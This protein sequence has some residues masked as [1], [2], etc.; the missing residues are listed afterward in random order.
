LFVLNSQQGLPVVCQA[1][2][3]R[4]LAHPLPLERFVSQYLSCTL[5]NDVTLPLGYRAEDVQYQLA[6]GC[7][8]V[9][10]V[11]DGT[12]INA[13]LFEYVLCEITEVTN[14]PGEAIEL[15]DDNYVEV[16]P[17]AAFYDLLDAFSIEVLG[18]YPFVPMYFNEIPVLGQ[19]EGFDFALLVG[20]A[21]TLS[22]LLFRRNP[23]ISNSALHVNH[24]L[25][26]LIPIK[27]VFLILFKGIK[28]MEEEVS[29]VRYGRGK[30]QV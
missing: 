2:S 28:Q 12:E 15:V 26:L 17:M 10:V 22:G 25:F 19:G 16:M 9:E 24:L 23:D 8:S 1:P 4:N 27:E 11:L 21:D 20:K 29:E 18:R 3:V 7:C 14:G 6:I 13:S 30:I 5:C